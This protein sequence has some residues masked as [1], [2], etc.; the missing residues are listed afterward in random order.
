MWPSFLRTVWLICVLMLCR[1]VVK[2]F[3]YYHSQ[4]WD[5]SEQVYK[6]DARLRFCRQRWSSSLS[7]SWSSYWFCWSFW[8]W[9]RW[10]QLYWSCW[11]CGWLGLSEWNLLYHHHMVWYCPKMRNILCWYIACIN[12]CRTWIGSFMFPILCVSLYY[13]MFWFGLV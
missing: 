11:Q 5:C 6:A 4:R 8:S 13:E 10:R 2:D 12:F 9:L 7:S 1:V 3:E